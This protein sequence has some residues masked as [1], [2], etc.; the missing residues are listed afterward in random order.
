MWP[1]KKRDDKAAEPKGAQLGALLAFQGWPVVSAR[2]SAAEDKLL[3]ILSSSEADDQSGT[4]RVFIGSRPVPVAYWGGE[5]LDDETP[6]DITTEGVALIP[7]CGMLVNMEPQY[8]FRYYGYCSTPMIGRMI[9]QAAADQRVSKILLYIS[10]PGGHSAGISEVAAKIWQVREAGEKRILGQGDD[11]CSAAYH[12]GSQCEA[13]YITKS[14]FSGCIGT[15][16]TPADWSEMYAQFGIKRL[17]I[18]STGAETLKGAGTPGTKIT[19]EQQ[20]DWKRL[21]DEIQSLFNADVMRARSFSSDEMSALA[22]GQ[23]WTGVVGADKKLVDGVASA[24]DVL[25]ALGSGGEVECE[26]NTPAPDNDKDLDDPASDDEATESSRG[27]KNLLEEPMDEKVQQS[28]ADKIVAGISKVI[29]SSKPDP[30][31]AELEKL[32]AENAKRDADALASAREA[33]TAAATAA[34][35]PGTSE[36]TGALAVIA[37]TENTSVLSELASAYKAKVSASVPT[38]RQTATPPTTPPAAPGAPQS[39]KTELTPEDYSAIYAQHN[40][41]GTK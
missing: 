25:A 33:A 5:G 3:A 12:L 26:G 41:K 19:P 39:E 11:I 8:W 9:D 20:A 24:A 30:A 40:N 31:K 22:T 2:R 16:M 13:L 1:F 21:C 23:Y 29:G 6:Y 14:G 35:G 27:T 36:L 38:G 34:Y 18:T 17:R 37:A 32:K 4:D 7:V 28:L 15:L 10:S